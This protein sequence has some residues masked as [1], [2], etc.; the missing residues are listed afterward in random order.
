MKT[1]INDSKTIDENIS[2][3]KKAVMGSPYVNAEN[4]FKATTENHMAQITDAWSNSILGTGDLNNIEKFS[5]YSGL[6]NSTLNY[7]L[8]TALYNDN[9]IMKKVVDKPSQ[10]MVRAGVSIMGNADFSKVYQ[11]LDDLKTD[12]INALKWSK[13]YGGSIMVILFKGISFDKMEEPISWDL[14]KGSK[15]VKSYVTDRWFGCSPS[16]NDTVSNL[17]NEDFGKPKYYDVQFADGTHHKIHHSWILRF[18]N[19][20]APKLI[21]TG[22][23]QGWGYAEGSHILK[24]LME[25]AELK[26]AIQ[27]LINKALIEVVHMPGMR[28][29]FMGAKTEQLEKRLD[30]VNWARNYN[31]LTL[32]DKDDQYE[33]HTFSGIAGLSDVLQ[34]NMW[35]IAAACDM[36]GILFGDLSNG[37]S[38]DSDALERYNEKILNDCETYYRQ[39]L[40]KLIRMLFHM[41]EVTDRNTGK[42]PMVAFS[43]NSIIVDK[44]NENKMA[45]IERILSIGEKMIDLKLIDS[46]GLAKTL[47]EYLSTGSFNISITSKNENEF[48]DKNKTNELLKGS[49]ESIDENFGNGDEGDLSLGSNILSQNSGSNVESDFGSPTESPQNQTQ[50]EENMNGG[51]NSENANANEN[52]DNERNFEL[53]GGNNVL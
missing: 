44:K 18:E 41:Y 5:S 2:K 35:I 40:R 52:N 21:E 33:Q 25:D 22:M 49:Q 37:F 42:T 30:F 17:A 36:A 16:Y 53:Q 46:Y 43:F 4:E 26:G 7:P 31:S 48:V 1:E 24:V 14:I 6:D 13:L 47:K 23:L 32:L 8:W 38:T 39:P 11:A 45:D 28:G 19:R 51:S 12:L 20:K 50:G 29:V 27:S 15:S 10:D 9:W 34:Q 3:L